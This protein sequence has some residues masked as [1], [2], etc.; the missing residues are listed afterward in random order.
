MSVTDLPCVINWSIDDV[1]FWLEKKKYLLE[2]R[3]LFEIQRIDGRALL[4]LNE[5]D[6]KFMLSNQPLGCIKKL[7]LDIQQL[8]LDNK[9]M[10]FDKG[11]DPNTLLYMQNKQFYRNGF[12]NVIGENSEYYRKLNSKSEV[13]EP[14]PITHYCNGDY[15]SNATAATRENSYQS[16]RSSED[17]QSISLKPEFTKAVIALAYL[18]VVTWITSFVMVIVHDRVPDMK[19]YPPLPDIFLDNVPYIPWAFHMCEWTATVLV[20]IWVVVLVFHKY[21]FILLRRFFALCGT[22]FLLRCITMLITSLSVPGSHLKCSP[23]ISTHTSEYFFSDILSKIKQAYIIWT[24]AGLSIRG[25]RTCGDYM[26]SGHSVVLTMLNFFITEY[27]SRELH[28]LHIFTWVLNMFGIFFILSGHEHYSIDVFIAFYITSRLFLYYHTL[29]NN[30]ALMQRDSTRTRIWFPLFSFFESSIEGIVP[31]EY[32]TVSEIFD[33]LFACGKFIFVRL[34]HAKIIM[35][36]K[37]HIIKIKTAPIRTSKK[38][39]SRRL[40]KQKSS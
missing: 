28:L 15:L 27:T 33:N 35:A 25:V 10:L 21:R 38:Q 40:K 5:Q 19:R 7:L 6:V 2:I 20:L 22:V 12:H 36:I 3:R 24:N 18:F 37:S 30:Q 11:Y 4:L 31:N 1:L 14:L 17:G 26:F 29:A 9:Q 23:R 34:L 32:E 13:T 8:K 16:S 39:F